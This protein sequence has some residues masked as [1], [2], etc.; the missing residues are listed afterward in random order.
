MQEDFNALS[1]YLRKCCKRFFTVSHFFSDSPP[2][3][4]DIKKDQSGLNIVGSPVSLTQLNRAIYFCNVFILCVIGRCLL[5]G[6]WAIE[7]LVEHEQV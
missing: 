1:L 2:F 5:F 6:A 4:P 7:S 3:F